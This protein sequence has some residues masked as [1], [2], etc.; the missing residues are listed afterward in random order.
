MQCGH[1]LFEASQKFY[2]P[3]EQDHPHFVLANV[4]NQ[5]RLESWLS[6]L[7]DHGIHYYVWR[8]PDL[9]NQITAIATEPVSGDKR[10][11]FNKLQLI[12]EV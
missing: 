6:K 9:D 10:R 11:V 4:K 3:E 8:E 7:D 2:N 5:Q 1:A 12:K